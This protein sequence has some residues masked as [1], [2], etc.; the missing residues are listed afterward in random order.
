MNQTLVAVS[1]GIVVLAVAFWE[2]HQRRRPAA[3]GDA[4]ACSCGGC[5]C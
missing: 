4:A 5:A 1:V 2:L 3:A